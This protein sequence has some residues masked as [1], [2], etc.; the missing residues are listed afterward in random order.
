MVDFVGKYGNL[1]LF[2]D[3]NC[4]KKKNSLLKLVEEICALYDSL[5]SS[6]LIL[7]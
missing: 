1:Y 7:H 4:L 3:F 6:C 5:F 2:P